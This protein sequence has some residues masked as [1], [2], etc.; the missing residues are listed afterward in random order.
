MSST[1][2]PGVVHV[3]SHAW[4]MSLRCRRALDDDTTPYK[5][6]LSSKSAS[7]VEKQGPMTRSSW[8]DRAGGELAEASGRSL[9]C[10]GSCVLAQARIRTAA[11]RVRVQGRQ[12]KRVCMDGVRTHV[13]HARATRCGSATHTEC[14]TTSKASRRYGFTCVPGRRGHATSQTSATTRKPMTVGSS[15]HAT[16]YGGA[17]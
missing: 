12:G 4:V 6:V 14:G 5:G 10:L 13:H 17:R 7:T 1:R 11:V 2:R 3:S 16:P 15:R 8:R 9:L